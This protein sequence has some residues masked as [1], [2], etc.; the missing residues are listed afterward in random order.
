MLLSPNRA[1]LVA[2]L[3]GRWAVRIARPLAGAH[4][5][6]STTGGFRPDSEAIY[7]GRSPDAGGA[8]LDPR[9]TAHPGFSLLHRSRQSRIFLA[10]DHYR[11][12]KQALATR[13]HYKKRGEKP[14]EFDQTRL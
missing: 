4:Q 6:A 13:S 1:S 9:A 7:T 8:H 5:S 14:P 11:R 2:C 12:Y 3:L 10:L